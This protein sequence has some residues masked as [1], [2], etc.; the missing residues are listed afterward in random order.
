MLSE[1][2]YLEGKLGVGLSANSLVAMLRTSVGKP[3]DREEVSK[4]F[5]KLK[6]RLPELLDLQSIAITRSGREYQA[7]EQGGFLVF[8]LSCH[9]GGKPSWMEWAGRASKHPNEFKRKA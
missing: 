6:A 3:A 8:T 5:K 7:R 2:V 4:S 9:F 1:I